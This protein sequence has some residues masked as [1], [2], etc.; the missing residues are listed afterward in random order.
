MPRRVKIAARE[1]QN[2]A[3]DPGKSSRLFN[4]VYVSPGEIGILRKRQGKAF[5]YFYGRSEIVEAETLGRIQKLAIPP[6]LVETKAMHPARL[7]CSV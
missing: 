4:L 6:A 3:G 1:L 7:S 2:A 5:R